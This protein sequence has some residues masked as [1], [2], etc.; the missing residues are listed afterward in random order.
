MSMLLRQAKVIHP[1]SSFHGQ[2][3]DIL[4]KEG[5][6]VSISSSIENTDNVPE[7]A[8]PGLTLSTGWVD[9][10]ADY[11]EPGY[12]HKETIA[13][14]LDAAR[15]GGFTDVLLL[16]NTNPVIDSKSG[17]Q[18]LL[19]RAAG[20][21]VRLHPLGAV[22]REIA[23]K[24]LAEMLDMRAHGAIAF[25]DGWHPVQNS[26]LLLKAL[27]YVKAFKGIILQMPVDTSLSAGGL[28]HEGEIS[29]RLG[30]PGIPALAET[31]MVHRDIE[32]VRYTG[33]RLH[34]TGISAAESVAMIRA[35]KAE[36][37]DVTCSVTP[38]HLALN[39]EALLQYSSLYKVT[40][41]LRSEADRQALIEGLSDGTI[42]CIASHHHPQDWDAKSRE[43]EYAGSG[44]N[45]QEMVFPIVW[46]AVRGQVSLERLTDALST[47]AREIF[48]L[49]V[50]APDAGNDA[51]FT[52]FT[53]EQT[54]TFQQNN[55]KSK[56][57]NNPF[58]GKELQGKVLS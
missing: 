33:S 30:M 8:V 5:R 13:S 48:N 34:I 1:S 14:G 29:T 58:L 26:S 40:P 47:R 7:I 6:I 36:G 53:T 32:L 23:G 10:F 24:A 37:L 35:A 22:S 17:V 12:E 11:C 18:A 19:Q 50:T 49:P 51:S 3:A 4:I 56:G 45:V 52:I 43:F 54:S 42:D 15:A 55:L 20:H 44:M 39:D 38:Y 16:P 28:M 57:M 27:E 2:S 21:T 31:L 46:N 41:P 25:T 9:L